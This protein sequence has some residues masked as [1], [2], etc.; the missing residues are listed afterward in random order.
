[1]KLSR[2]YV[3]LS[4]KFKQVKMVELV[5]GD[6]FVNLL[7]T[8]D[9]IYIY[10]HKSK[11]IQKVK[12]ELRAKLNSNIIRKPNSSLFSNQKLDQTHVYRSL[13]DILSHHLYKIYCKLRIRILILWRSL[14]LCLLKLQNLLHNL[15]FF[16][17]E[18]PHNPAT[19]EGAK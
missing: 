2:S 6:N 5:Q 13:K 14:L 4:V 11:Q 10:K 16:N 18:G 9:T 17:Q 19:E 8:I 7:T 12:S 3:I 1:M 15:L